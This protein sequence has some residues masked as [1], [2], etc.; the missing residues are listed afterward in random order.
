MPIDYWQSERDALGISDGTLRLSAGLEDIED[1]IA[2]FD[3]AQA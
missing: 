2:D 1:L 3:Q